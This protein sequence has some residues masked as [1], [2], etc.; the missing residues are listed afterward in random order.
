MPS[1]YEINEMIINKITSAIR[2]EFSNTEILSVRNDQTQQTFT[3][4][5][6]VVLEYDTQEEHLG[7]SVSRYY[8]YYDITLHIEIDST[9]RRGIYSYMR[10]YGARMSRI[11]DYITLESQYTNNRTIKLKKYGWRTF[12]QDGVGHCMVEY[13]YLASTKS[14]QA[15]TPISRVDGTFNYEKER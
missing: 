4:P 6:I 2:T 11:L 10:E 5:A 15:I 14:G 3:K 9:S 13:H 7:N 12:I 8:V 1:G